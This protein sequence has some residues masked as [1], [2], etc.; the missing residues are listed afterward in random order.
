MSF[1]KSLRWPIA[2]AVSAGLGI[3]AAELARDPVAGVV[4]SVLM[5]AGFGLIGWELAPWKGRGDAKR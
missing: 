4:A 5:L 2:V 1:V 3:I